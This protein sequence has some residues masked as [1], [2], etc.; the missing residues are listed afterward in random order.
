MTKNK[1]KR[2]K[3]AMRQA[4]NRLSN[5]GPNDNVGAYN[6]PI[7]IP[8]MKKQ[9]DEVV[10]MM[11]ITTTAQSTA[12]GLDAGVASSDPTGQTDWSSVSGEYDEYRVLGMCW[13]FQ[14]YN[15]YAQTLS[16]AVHP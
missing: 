12:G 5:R 11:S 8:G 3:I 9:V 6:G 2:V 4:G 16:I 1:K 10:R 14:P 7:A 15:R 13:R